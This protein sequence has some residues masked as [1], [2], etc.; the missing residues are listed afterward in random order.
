M[1]LRYEISSKLQQLKDGEAADVSS[2]IVLVLDEEEFK[3][4]DGVKRSMRSDMAYLLTSESCSVD[5]VPEGLIGSMAIPNKEDLMGDRDLFSFY[6]TPYLL[7]FV[8]DGLVCAQTMK[9]VAASNLNADQTTFG[10][11]YAFLRQ[12]LIGD[13]TW[14]G[15]LEDKMEDAEEGM[16]DDRVDASPESITAYRRASIRMTAYYQQLAE[17]VEII[18]SNENGMLSEGEVS[19]FEQLVGKIDRLEARAETVREH[20]VQLRELHQTQLDMKQN[21]VM[22]I[23]TLVTVLFAP[24]TLMAGWFGMNF[25]GMPG[26][27]DP[28]GFP[29]V[30][31]LGILITVLL[32]IWFRKK[33]WL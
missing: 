32:L 3:A 11:L 10:C 9:S 6:C 14:L 26:I 27:N 25:A 17:M 1:T 22:Q 13:P 19:E 28:W 7:V 2:P 31:I 33:K 21:N 24:L 15:L 5:I 30:C 20:S 16:L 18:S 8:D 12:L 29:L 23:L 4:F